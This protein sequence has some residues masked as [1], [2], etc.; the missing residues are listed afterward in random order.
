MT[1]AAKRASIES[2]IKL[3]NDA[4]QARLR[5]KEDQALDLMQGAVKKE[6]EAGKITVAKS[7][8]DADTLARYKANAEAAQKGIKESSEWLGKIAALKDNPLSALTSP[9]ETWK[10]YARYG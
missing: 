6:S 5:A 1:V 8:D 2:K 7:E 3:E 10:M 9:L 4:D